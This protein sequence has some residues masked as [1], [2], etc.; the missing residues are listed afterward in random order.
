MKKLLLF[1]NQEFKAILLLGLLFLFSNNSWGQQVIGSFP[2]MDG[3]F[4]GQ[5]ATT[6]ISGT[7]S[8]TA[9]TVS[10]TGNSS[11]RAIVSDAAIARSG[12]KFASHTTTATTV[13]LQSPYTATAA[14]APAPSTAYI[15]QFYYNTITDQTNSIQGSIYNTTVA[16]NNSKSALVIS[17]YISG[18]WTKAYVAL[19]SN[20]D[21]ISATTN[22]A[23]VRHLL[24]TSSNIKIDDFVVY[25]GTSV[26]ETAPSPPSSPSVSGSNISW[27][28][29]TDV[30]G[31]G[32]VV[33]RYSSNPNANNDP[34]VNG[35]YA[36]GN[37][38]TNGSGSLTGT[39]VY[40]GTETSFTDNVVAGAASG[41]YYKIYT[42]DK[43]FNY[44]EEIIGTAVISNTPTI[45]SN[46]SQLDYSYV[47]NNTSKILNFNLSAS[48]LTS[49]TGNIAIT[50]TGGYLVSTSSSGTFT[51]SI[52]VSYSGNSLSSTPIY[53]KFSPTISQSYTGTISFSGGGATS[54]I[55][56]TGN[57][58]DYNFGTYKS[59]A[60][61]NWLSSGTWNKWNGTSWTTASD[62]PNSATSDVYIS[63]GGTVTYNPGASGTTGVNSIASAKSCNNLY[64]ELNSTLVSNGLV[65]SVKWLNV[66]GN[67]VNV[68][69]GSTLGN[70][71]TGNNADGICLNILSNN[72]TISGGGSISI[73]RIITNIANTNLIIDTDVTLNYHGSSNAGHATG[74]YIVAGDNNIL[75]VNTGKTLTFAP[76]SCLLYTSGGHSTSS[77]LSQTINLYGT[78][79]FVDGDLSGTLSTNIQNGWAGHTNNYFSM[80]VNNSAISTLNVY[81]GGVLNV[82][83]FY[84]NGTN[85]SNI[86]GGGNVVTINVANGGKI[87][88]S[89]IADFRN[90]NQTVTGGGEF[91][92]LS[93]AT[94]KIGAANGISNSAT[95]GPIRTTTRGFNVGSIY[96]YEGTSSQVTG[97]GMPSN[98]NG[99][100]INNSS[101]V[102]LTSPVTIDGSIIVSSGTLITGSNNLTLGTS[103][104]ATFGPT[105]SLSISGGITNFNNR[106]VTFQSTVAGTARIGT[107]TGSLTGDTNVTVERYIPSGKR[108]FRLLS[109]AVTTTNFISGNWQLATHITGGLGTTGLGFDTT[110]TNNPSMFTYNNQVASGSG[111]EAITN[112]NAT[113]LT[114]GVGYR[115]LVR[116]D[117]TTT[118]ITAATTDNM[119]AAITLSATGTL[120]TGTVTLN[121]SSTPAINN[122]I[123]STT[124]DYS[125]VGNPYQ[126]AVDWNALTKSG[127]DASYYAW[128]PNMGTSIQRGRYVVFNGT[129]NNVD[130]G[131]GSSN[132]GQFI[133]P[134]QAFFV[135]N[136]VPGTAGILTFQEAHKASTNANVF[137][138]TTTPTLA[139]ALYDPNELALGGYPIDATKAVFSSDYSNELGLGDATKL[140]AAGENIA[141]FRNNTKLAIDAAAPVT[142]SDELVMKTLRLGANKNYTFKIQTTNFD[143]ALTPYLVD[144]FLNTQTEITTSQVFLASFA[145]TSNATS[146]SEN[147]FKV[148]FSASSTLSNDQWDAKTLHIYPNPVVDNQF[149]IG[150][151]SSI[152]DKVTIT[153]YNIIGQSVYQVSATPINNTIQVQPNVELKAGVYMVEMTHNGQTNTQKII[154][155]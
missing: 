151:S 46:Y 135:K 24:T 41:D 68:A 80:N 147:R 130:G 3:G 142:T 86:P 53:V 104:A 123:N 141:W 10:S 26:D 52:N 81:N 152:T 136:T 25:S 45:S 16:G 129:V 96:S 118:N 74:F 128:D 49:A 40:V 134:G 19:T 22:F 88:V 62:F 33:V 139:V 133:Q 1:K 63:G 124:A 2:Y 56:I 150:V 9:W 71:S 94:L 61:G 153:I 54:S 154:V 23:G 28:A 39:V 113:N 146:Y 132:V 78:L 143:T 121:A 7:A 111:W 122:Q 85:A 11:T 55:T 58:S 75:T 60:S 17:T 87:N 93:G 119:N 103:S 67:L 30:D 127:I 70:T 126:S 42:V 20:T 66:Y 89:K 57:G 106:P 65:N 50:A 37:T 84:P 47:K 15:V 117:R 107:I 69:S 6:S 27:I 92:L 112:T 8:T 34:N 64:I 99:L 4:E 100:T 101:G 120:R 12:S 21:A 14:Y 18:V 82:S 29:S 155:K 43:A 137:R 140:E 5:T 145:T 36:I 44:S 116:G 38:I 83:E 76:W 32:Y 13:R 95:T 131:V 98:V 114:A 149:T 115:M 35:I 102:T 91:N 31:G 59:V 79:T 109:P 48:S 97:D 110:E 77:N 148:V 73:S 105:S 51:S 125:L 90:I 108:A 144:N 138:T 72:M